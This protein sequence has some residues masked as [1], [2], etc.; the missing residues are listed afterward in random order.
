M[1]HYPEPAAETFRTP[2]GR[3]ADLFNSG[4]YPVQ[5]VCRVCSGSIQ[6]DS[7]LR[8]FAHTDPAS[9]SVVQFPAHGAAGGQVRDG[10]R[11]APVRPTALAA[12]VPAPL[13]V[14]SP[15]AAAGGSAADPT[16]PRGL[17]REPPESPARPA[18][19]DPPGR[20]RRTQPRPTGNG[21]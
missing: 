2:D 15:G 9:T 20:P 11:L 21:R 19:G 14:F 16:P 7:F 5:A 6:A 10:T 4:H 1:T 12:L 18:R 8:P 17:R 3:Q 13:P